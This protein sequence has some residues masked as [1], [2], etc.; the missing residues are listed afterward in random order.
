MWIDL[1]SDLGDDAG[2][3][4]MAREMRA[5]PAAYGVHIIRFAQ[6]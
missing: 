6:T 4:E 1:N 5:R 3:C 2:A